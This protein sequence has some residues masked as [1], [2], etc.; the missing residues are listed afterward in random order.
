MVLHLKHFDMEWRN[1]NYSVSDD[2]TK[3]DIPLIHTFLT[4]SYW[5]AG[6]PRKTVERSIRHS[7]CF[8]IYNSE[9]QVGFA[10]VISDHATYAYLA[11]VFILPT[12]RG[13]GLSKWLMEIITGHPELQGLRRFVLATKDA[14][15][16]YAPFGFTAYPQPDRLMC[17]HDPDVYS[18][19][20]EKEE[21]Y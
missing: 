21:K 9:A 7:L 10:R 4:S 8:G 6:I 11:D 20:Q 1:G 3:L 19:S 13:K 14:H 16:L 15:G 5:A 17:R 12:E 2:P 18:R